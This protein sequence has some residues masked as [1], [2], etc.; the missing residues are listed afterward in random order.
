MLETLRVKFNQWFSQW[1]ASKEA[2]L[3]VQSG[4][5]MPNGRARSDDMAV[6]ARYRLMDDPQSARLVLV[7]R[8]QI[9]RDQAVPPFLYNRPVRRHNLEVKP[10]G[11][12]WQERGWVKE[13]NGWRG[14]YCVRGRSWQGSAEPIRGGALNMYIHEPP[15]GLLTGPHRRCYID[16]DAGRL[17]ACDYYFAR[18]P[19]CI[20]VAVDRIASSGYVFVQPSQPGEACWLCRYPDAWA[21]TAVDQRCAGSE[22][23]LLS[24][25]VGLVA[26]AVDSLLM[27]RKRTWSYFEVFLDG[28]L[29]GGGSRQI[30]VRS[31]CP[32]CGP[33]PRG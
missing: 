33:T 6:P 3:Q 24:T 4:T 2:D 22:P 26:Y 18:R 15:R 28:T 14:V 8:H 1:T 5:S 16:N 7:I 27:P 29:A 12:L 31:T 30:P 17:Y 13:G 32:I 20:F 19:P 23:G 10:Q 9:P 11:S 21:G 25:I